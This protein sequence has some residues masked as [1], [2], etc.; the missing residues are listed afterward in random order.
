MG[1]FTPTGYSKKYCL[2]H[3]WEVAA[4]K[5]RDIHCAWQRAVKGYCY[6]DVWN[7]DYWFLRTMPKMIDDLIKVHH[8]Y[9]GEMT[10]KEWVETLKKMSTAFKN[11]NEETTEFI[12]PY[13]DEYFENVDFSFEDQKLI[14]DVDE[15]LS[16]K[17]HNEEQKKIAFMQKSLDEGMTLFHKHFRGLWD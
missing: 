14:C 3:P 6:R 1:I 2:L 9:P 15:V 5:M 16:D 10:D 11:A 4:H 17:Y 13:E 7:I 8:G 12:N